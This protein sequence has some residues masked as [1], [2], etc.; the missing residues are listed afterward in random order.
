MTFSSTH[1]YTLDELYM[2]MYRNVFGFLV[3]YAHYTML[4]FFDD[5]G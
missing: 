1:T 5:F 2:Y 3:R 4:K